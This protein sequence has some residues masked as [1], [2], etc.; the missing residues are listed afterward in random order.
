VVVEKSKI[1]Q[2]LP[3]GYLYTGATSLFLI[4][5]PKQEAKARGK[6]KHAKP[7]LPR[8]GG[9]CRIKTSST[10]G[11]TRALSALHRSGHIKVFIII[12]IILVKVY[13]GV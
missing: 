5:E 12:I 10:W 8:K 6:Q 11:T 4:K 1:E 9:R 7:H 2:I 13:K 3:T